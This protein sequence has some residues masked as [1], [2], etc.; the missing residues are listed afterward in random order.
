MDTTIT[1]LQSNTFLD[2]INCQVHT[3]YKVIIC[4]FCGAAWTPDALLGHIKN[5]HPDIQMDPEA[6]SKLDEVKKTYSILSDTT[7]PLPSFNGPPVEGLKTHKDGLVCTMEDC[8]Y[9]CRSLQSM[10]QHWCHHRGSLMPKSKRSQNAVVQCFF[11][12]IG[13]RYF[14][15]N[16]SLEGIK[17]EG[18]YSAFIRDYLPSLPPVLMDSPNTHREVPPLLAHTGWNIHL[19]GFVTDEGKRQK[20]VQSA[21]S[22]LPK[23]QDPLYGQLYDWVFDYMNNIRDIATHQV[24]Y[25]LLRYLLQYPWYVCLHSLSKVN[26]ILCFQSQGQN[27][28][29]TV[30]RDNTTLKTY[31]NALVDLLAF[32]L[33][34]L[35]NTE[36]EYKLP[37]N[38][39]QVALGRMLLEALHHEEPDIGTMHKLFYTFMAPPMDDQPF[40][41]WNDALLCFLAVTNLRD[42][43]TFESA[44][45]LTG[46]LVR[47]E[48]NMRG[49]GLFEAVNGSS[50]FGTV[51]E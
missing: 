39:N 42:D 4:M 16:P 1:L 22:P 28:G 11:T 41:K 8:I 33:R 19:E 2:S 50:G 35:D 49:A 14:S 12:V 44:H 6:Q 18:L 40:S 31:G 43:G 21:R 15:V 24:P 23:S 36:E 27:R 47:W 17:P 34:T 48:Y 29:W 10:D 20:L 38:E 51:V 32:T 30:H 9:A 46:Q 25:T 13:R 3:L 37:L 5:E 45:K 7:V 26:V